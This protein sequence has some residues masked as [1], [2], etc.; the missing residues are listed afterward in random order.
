[1]AQVQSTWFPVIEG[2]S[3]ESVCSTVCRGVISVGLL[4]G[5]SVATSPA[6]T[7][8]AYHTSPVYSPGWTA[9]DS[10][11][12]FEQF[13]LPSATRSLV[14][15]YGVPTG[16]PGFTAGD[17]VSY[18]VPITGIVYSSRR[19]PVPWVETHL[20][21]RDPAGRLREIKVAINCDL[22]RVAT[23]QYP[24]E[25][26]GCWMPIVLAPSPLHPY[27]AATISDSAG[28]Q[29]AFDATILLMNHEAFGD[30]LR[31]LPTWTEPIKRPE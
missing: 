15:L 22:H 14:V 17:T 1:M 9:R 20:A 28:L 18:A 12:R 31:P 16:T 11:L 8:L 3:L 23:R 4:A 10:T 29:S 24:G 5:C 21:R 27:M 6:R 7:E 19:V 26:F 13:L 25:T 30:R 2:I